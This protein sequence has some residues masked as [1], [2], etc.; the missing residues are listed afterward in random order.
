MAISKKT[1]KDVKSKAKT[2]DKEK[3]AKTAK[4]EK[5]KAAK[6]SPKAV[7]TTS[8][9]KSEN[10]GRVKEPE[11]LLA[12]LEIVEDEV[13]LPR[14]VVFYAQ[15]LAFKPIREITLDADGNKIYAQESP[16][17]VCWFVPHM[18]SH[19]LYLHKLLTDNADMYPPKDK[20]KPLKYNPDCPAVLYHS[21]AKILFNAAQTLPL[22]IF[23]REKHHLSRPPFDMSLLQKVKGKKKKVKI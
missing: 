19:G 9:A 4:A 17:G 8:Q 22:I 3:A 11:N 18:L 23:D 20:L 15:R 16:I 5:P 6:E 21:Y 14:D 1:N 10:S 7:K 13:S 12:G 2:P